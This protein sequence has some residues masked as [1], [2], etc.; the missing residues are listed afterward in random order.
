MSTPKRIYLVRSPIDGTE[1]L[2]RA[3][4]QS[5]ARAHCARELEVSVASQ[6]QIVALLTLDAP[7]RV[8]E[9]GAEPGTA[10]G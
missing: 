4:N 7:V 1:R 5:R 6:D 8:E 2:V 3:E 9:A 10:N